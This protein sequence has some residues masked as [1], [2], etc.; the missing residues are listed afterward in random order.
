[1]TYR[2]VRSLQR[3]SLATAVAAAC[4]G[5]AG[6]ASADAVDGVVNPA[7][8][9][10]LVGRDLTFSSVGKASAKTFSVTEPFY[11]RTFNASST[12]C[13]EGARAIA[14]FTPAATAGPTATF[15]VTPVSAG[16]CTIRVEDDN[17][18]AVRIAVVVA[19]H[20]AP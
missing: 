13:G 6:P 11:T 7:S 4:A 16:T 8:S 12:S 14:R 1:M 3:L 9:I 17:S 10:R 19:P 2:L 5:G 15:T 18:G 20:P